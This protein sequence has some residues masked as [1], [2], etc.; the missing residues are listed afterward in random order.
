MVTDGTH[1]GTE[2]VSAGQKCLNSDMSVKS[3][4]ACKSR[5]RGELSK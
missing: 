4:T 5:I 2:E 3:Q 1:H